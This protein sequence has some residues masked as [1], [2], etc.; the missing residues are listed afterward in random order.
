MVPAAGFDAIAD[1]IGKES[2]EA[3]NSAAIRKFRGVY[4]V[5][6]ES[7]K[8]ALDFFLIR[9]FFEA[10]FLEKLRPELSAVSSE[11]MFLGALNL[12]LRPPL[13]AKKGRGRLR[14]ER[15]CL[16]ARDQSHRVFG[17]NVKQGI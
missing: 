1:R 15:L 9:L 10:G 14:A 2:I 7:R 17:C 12:I 8:E 13:A 11:P 3:A 16:V 4:D 6:E 5:K